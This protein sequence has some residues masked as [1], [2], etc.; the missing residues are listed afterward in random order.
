VDAAHDFAP[1]IRHGQIGQSPKDA[2]SSILGVWPTAR[3]SVG[4]AR[5][6][7]HHGQRMA[8]MLLAEATLIGYGHWR[9]PEDFWIMQR[10][11][12]WE[13]TI[14]MKV[15]GEPASKGR[16]GERL[17][18]DFQRQVIE[19]MKT[20][21]RYPLTGP[22]ALDLHFAS[23]LRNPPMIYS[24][25]KYALDV[26]GPALPANAEPR[27]RSVLYRDDRQ[28]K[29]LF[30]ELSQRWDP[31]NTQRAVPGWTW[32]TARRATD[33]VH[34]LCVVY[35][36]DLEDD[37]DTHDYRSHYDLDDDDTSPFLVP[38]LPDDFDWYDETPPPEPTPE[39]AWLDDRVRFDRT[40]R[41]Q[42]SVLARTDAILAHSLAGYLEG[43]Q[44]SSVYADLLADVLR[45]HH[46]V[47]L[48]SQISIPMPELPDQKGSTAAFEQMARQQLAAFK[49][50]HRLFTTLLAPIKL[51]FLVIPP[52]QGKDLDNLAIK[53]LPIAHDVLKPHI[54]PHWLAPVYPDEEGRA[55]KA[56]ASK[57]LRSINANSVRCYQVIELPRSPTDPPEGVLRL[58]LGRDSR[59]SWWDKAA[60]YLDKVIERRDYY[61]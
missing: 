5:P 30:A 53:I 35:D 31:R 4:F 20:Y 33:A 11:V 27:R 1:G 17:A 48:S 10:R 37:S 42:E 51:I 36:L 3:A 9:V 29:F 60:R 38:N 13:R 43:R 7:Q 54:E 49:T 24:A 25:A 47:L 12:R 28:V 16:R 23:M 19:S 40:M 6:R 59:H 46:E 34:D 21:R 18:P 39:Q 8:G 15:E 52:R 56:E 44:V 50:R 57:R 2:H 58:A 14:L 32:L 61:R 26:L 45:H 22:V 41:L 55:W